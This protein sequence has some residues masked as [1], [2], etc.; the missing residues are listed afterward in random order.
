MV[1][2]AVRIEPIDPDRHDRSSFCCR[3]PSL[4][5]WLRDD[6]PTAGS[7]SGVRVE[8]AS[9]DDQVVG[10]YR[11]GSFQVEAGDGLERFGSERPP[12]PAILVSRLGVDTR[13][14]RRGLGTSLLMHAI[15]FAADAA[16]AVDAAL[17]VAQAENDPAMVFCTRL[18]FEP[19]R[20]K[21]GW[22]YLRLGTSRRRSR[23]QVLAGRGPAAQ[24]RAGSL[25]ADGGDSSSCCQRGPLV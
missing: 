17:L 18:G 4:D 12:L 13:W 8:V 14:Q 10:C 20:G 25:G 11:L 6:G 9:I 3:E 23:L 21:A 5:R 15:G 2:A 1:V 24:A 16:P 7:T 19:F 22:L